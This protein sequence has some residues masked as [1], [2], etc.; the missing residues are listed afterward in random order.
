M[1]TEY[2]ADTVPGMHGIEN[3]MFTEEYQVDYYAMNHKV[4]DEIPNFVGE[5]LWNFADF[6]TKQGINRVQGNKKGVFNRA[7]QPK[8]VVR[9]LKDRWESIP[10][11]NYKK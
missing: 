3:Q 11:F 2:G 6:E 9:S 5:Q 8:M 10:D 7:R 1:Y 4:F